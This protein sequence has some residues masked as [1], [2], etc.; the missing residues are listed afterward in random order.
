[1]QQKKKLCHDTGLQS[2]EKNEDLH[3]K[4]RRA[5]PKKAKDRYVHNG[6]VQQKQKVAIE[7]ASKLCN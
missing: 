7:V 1:M 3:P 5:A 6:T 2:A 4:V